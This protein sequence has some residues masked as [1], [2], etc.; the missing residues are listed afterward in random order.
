MTLPAVTETEVVRAVKQYLELRGFAVFRRNVGGAYSGLSFVRFSEP[1]QADLYG[2]ER[3]TG[4]HIEVEVKK[5][6]SR[7]NP[8]R[9]TLQRAWLDRAKRDGAIALR[10]ASVQEADEQLA[11]Y[12]YPRRLLV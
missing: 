1:G 10:V 11:E 5:P 9:D 7:T 2:W 3:A 6:G 8:K 4:R 12:G